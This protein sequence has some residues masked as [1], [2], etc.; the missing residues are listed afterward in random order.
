VEI[1]R[2]SRMPS[3]EFVSASTVAGESADEVA[4]GASFMIVGDSAPPRGRVW[5][6]MPH[7]RRFVGKT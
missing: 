4:S 6:N 7:A 2:A 1:L 3:D 5:S